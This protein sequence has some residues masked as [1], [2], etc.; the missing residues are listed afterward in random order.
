[1]KL[2]NYFLA[3][4]I[5]NR[6]I[7]EAVKSIGEQYCEKHWKTRNGITAWEKSHITLGVFHLEDD[8]LEDAKQLLDQ[9]VLQIKQIPQIHPITVKGGVS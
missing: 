7:L 4:P 6:R 8:E 3:I 2:R 5:L 1:M 9:C